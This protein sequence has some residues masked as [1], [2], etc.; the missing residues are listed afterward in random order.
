MAPY[1]ILRIEANSR[2]RVMSLCFTLGEAQ[3]QCALLAQSDA[4]YTYMVVAE[5]K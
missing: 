2:P 4:Q 5:V 3:D 1:Y